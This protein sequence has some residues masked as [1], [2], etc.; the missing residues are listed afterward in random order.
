MRAL[1]LGFVFFMG[2]GPGAS[3]PD[4]TF[5]VTCGELRQ[6]MDLHDLEREF[7]TVI[8]VEGEVIEIRKEGPLTYVLICEPPDPFVLCVTYETNGNVAGDRVAVRG[9]YS[10]PGVDHVML[11]P[12]LHANAAA[13]G[14]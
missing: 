8:A 1:L 5:H 4:P 9:A 10:R 12:C 2:V 6:A 3:Q 13:S 14:D 11:D 7:L